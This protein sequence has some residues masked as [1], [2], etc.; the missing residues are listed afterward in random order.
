M[1]NQ[2]HDGKRAAR[3]AGRMAAALAQ[4]RVAIVLCDYVFSYEC[5][6]DVTVSNITRMNSSG[7]CAL[8]RSRIR[9][10]VNLRDE[11]TYL[12]RVKI[13]HWVIWLNTLTDCLEMQCQS[14]VG[15]SSKL[16][17]YRWLVKSGFACNSMGGRG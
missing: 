5:V 7:A 12:V 1:F 14:F 2:F 3:E 8:S 13:E 9:E 6:R 4:H 11:I 17:L 16:T 10:E 15:V